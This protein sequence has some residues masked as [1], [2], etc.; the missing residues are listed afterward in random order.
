MAEVLQTLL[1]RSSIFLLLL[2]AILLVTGVASGITI[3]SFSLQ[4]SN[5]VLQW[6]VFAVGIILTIVGVWGEIKHSKSVVEPDNDN[7]DMPN[8]L[9]GLNLAGT[10]YVYFGFDTKR[11]KEN[12]VGVA[13]I[14]K[15]QGNKFKMTITLNKSKLG[16]LIHNVFEYDGIA[17][18]NQILCT[19]KSKSSLGGFMIGTMVMHPS[20]QGDKIFCGATYVN[21]FNKIVMDSCLLMKV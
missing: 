16:R 12:A 6:I 7:K 10:W 13:D 1:K 19:F 15:F 21:N 14:G 2:G 5:S 18:N 17:K 4:I 8:Q 3:G 9:E 20:P 11:T